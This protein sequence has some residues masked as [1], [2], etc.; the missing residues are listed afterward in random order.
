MSTPANG[1]RRGGQDGAPDFVINPIGD[2]SPITVDE[3]SALAELEG[4]HNL[5]HSRWLQAVINTEHGGRPSRPQVFC[6]LQTHLQ[7]FAAF[8]R[9]DF[10]AERKAVLVAFAVLRSRETR[11]ATG[12]VT[13]RDMWLLYRSHEAYVGLFNKLQL[14]VAAPHVTGV[15]WMSRFAIG[16]ELGYEGDAAERWF[17][18]NPLVAGLERLDLP[19][20]S[21]Y[22]V[23]EAAM[24]GFVEIG[25]VKVGHVHSLLPSRSQQA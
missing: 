8:P 21:I 3:M 11:P 13:L 1:D 7:E 23:R 10:E 2:G 16:W 4:G 18:T 19:I 25:G 5:A 22:D 20:D 14:G 12:E 24:E 9:R 6:A 17:V 15:A